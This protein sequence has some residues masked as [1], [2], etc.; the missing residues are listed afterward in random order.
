MNGEHAGSA[1]AQRY[2]L[3][4]VADR[5]VLATLFAFLAAI[6]IVP[7]SRTPRAA[8]APVLVA[9]ATPEQ[10]EPL[11]TPIPTEPEAPVK[12]RVGPVS[13]MPDAP[14]ISD[15][16]GF[17]SLLGDGL[18]PAQFRVSEH[19]NAGSFQGGDWKARNVGLSEGGA[20]LD[21]T[22]STSPA[23]PYDIAEMSTVQTYGYGRY[24]VVMRPAKGSGLVSS[25]FTY[26]GPH[27]GNPHDEIDVEFLGSDTTRVELNYFRKGLTGEH[28]VYD[29]PFDAADADHLYAFDWLPEGIIWYVDG[30][31]LWR[32]PPGDPMIPKTP[33]NI[34]FSNWTGTPALRRWHGSP[35]FG[36]RGSAYYSCVSFTPLGQNGRRCADLWRPEELAAGA[37]PVADY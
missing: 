34:M 15:T 14:P 13:Q 27:A 32:T 19:S 4:P 3:D 31:E 6:A 16:P 33:G 22:P 26:T 1:A 36:D 8:P 28:G 24:E 23:A 5:A 29:L 37:K 20:R 11:V 10:L 17:V 7:G 30:E 2:R 35:D 18:N 25:F 12:R 21:V 9:E